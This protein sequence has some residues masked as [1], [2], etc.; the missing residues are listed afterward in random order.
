MFLELLVAILQVAEVLEELVVL[1]EVVVL[2]EEPLP[3]VVEPQ[4]RQN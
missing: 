3:E 1:V 4:D 2:V